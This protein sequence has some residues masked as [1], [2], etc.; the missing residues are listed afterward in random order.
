PGQSVWIHVCSDEQIKTQLS[1]SA[2]RQAQGIA[3]PLFGVPFAVK[4]NIDVA[5]CPTTAA[6]PA[7]SYTPE[8]SAAVVQR[9]CDAGVIAMGKTNLDQF[10]AG[11]VGTRSPY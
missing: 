1:R 11:L 9:L 10:A 7:Y 3:Q 2:A 6:C 5:G 4:D 8:K